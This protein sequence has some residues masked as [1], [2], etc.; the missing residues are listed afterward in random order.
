M[1]GE[2]CLSAK[3]TIRASNKSFWLIAIYGPTTTNQKEAFYTEL[4][5]LKPQPGKGWLVCGDFNQIYRVR[6]KNKSSFDRRRISKFHD[7]LS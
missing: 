1:I 2:F 4:L 3:V 7:T 5:A 6:D